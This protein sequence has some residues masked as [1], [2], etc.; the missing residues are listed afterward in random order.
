MSC[1]ITY[2][3][4]DAAGNAA[5]EITRTVIIITSKAT[6]TIIWSNPSDI[7][8]G[9]ALSDTQLNATANVDGTFVYSPASGTVLGAGSQTLSVTFTPTD[10]NN[11]NP[12]T[13]TVS[14]TVNPA[15]SVVTTWPTASSITY[16]QTLADSTLSAGVSVTAGS[17]AFTTPT[18]APDAETALKA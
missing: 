18:T 16:G 13:Q 6:P 14:L 3:V 5:N 4:S 10:T 12:V 8:Y 7:T 2:N 17:F 11:Y 1:P 15:N 9:T